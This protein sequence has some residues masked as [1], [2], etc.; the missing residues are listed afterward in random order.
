MRRAL[1]FRSAFGDR[2]YAERLC[3]S[4]RTG[5]RAG[6]EPVRIELDLTPAQVMKQIEHCDGVLL[7]A[8][9]R[10]RSAEV[11][12]E[13]HEKT[14]PAD[15]KRDRVDSVLLADAYKLHKPV[16]GICYGLQSLNVYRS[17]SLVQDVESAMGDS[18]GV[19]SKINH[20]AGRAV[21]KAH[22]VRIE[23][24]RAGGIVGATKPVR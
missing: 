16:L 20:S 21:E 13:R 11:W 12:A 18:K 22:T 10:T 5:P 8:A 7:R 2:E 24:G 15:A 14:A 9:A 19:H 17:G 4:M 23:P 1:P 3:R 6:G